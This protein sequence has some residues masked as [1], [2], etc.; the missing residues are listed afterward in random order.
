MKQ[1]FGDRTIILGVDRLDYIKG[2]PQKLRAYEQFLTRYPE[3]K[4]KV[5]LVQVCVPSRANLE[6]NQKLRI[7]VQNLTGD[8]NGRYGSVN[9]VPIHFLYQ[10]ILPDELTAL[11]AVADVCFI[12]STRD[13]MNLVAYE[14]IACHGDRARKASAHP[15]SPGVVVLSK[16][17]GAVSTLKGCLIVNPWDQDECAEMLHRAVVMNRE[18]ASRNM[19]EANEVIQN[20]TRYMRPSHC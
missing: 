15:I 10:S 18:E 12:C 2:I 20:H 11:Y 14:Y 5:V 1:K 6:A 17:A 13:G 9:H 7:E 19:E 8:I 16:F 4:D 3:H